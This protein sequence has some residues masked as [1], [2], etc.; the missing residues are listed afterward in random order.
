MLTTIIAGVV[1]IVSTILAWVLNPKRRL[2]AELDDIYRQLD[3]LYEKRDKALAENDSD[4][5]TVIN[6]AIIKLRERKASLLQ[7]Q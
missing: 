4:T 6:F 5:I 1:G 7:R 3:S 2:Y